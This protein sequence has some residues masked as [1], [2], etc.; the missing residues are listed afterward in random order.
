MS[1]ALTIEPSEFC[2]VEQNHGEIVSDPG[3]RIFWYHRRI[4]TIA[5][6]LLSLASSG[7]YN[8]IH[9]LPPGVSYRGASH[10]DARAS[11]LADLTCVDGTGE[12]QVD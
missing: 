12:R 2:Q 10:Y 4:S 9:R 5:L 1:A 11:F 8:L 7:C 3:P 6:I